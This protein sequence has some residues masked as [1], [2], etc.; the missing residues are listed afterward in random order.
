MAEAEDVITDAARHATIFARGLWQR[1]RAVSGKQ[2]PA[3]LRLADVAPRIDLLITAVFGRSFAI[4]AAQPPA[5]PT[6]LARLLQ[7]PRERAPYW[8]AAIGATDGRQI[9][10]PPTFDGALSESAAVAHWR[11]LALRQAMR[12]VRAG[13]AEHTTARD[14][15]E[16]RRMLGSATPLVRDLHLLFEAY[17]AD[18]A[19]LRLL[20]GRRD[21][22]H[23]L[24][25]GS[26]A[27]RPSL[28]AFPARLQRFE[29]LVRHVLGGALNQHLELTEYLA[30]GDLAASFRLH[31]SAAAYI[32]AQAVAEDWP[33]AA[34][35]AQVA[36]PWLWR[37]QWTGD[38]RVGVD[39]A[40]AHAASVGTTG[41]AVDEDQVA[42]RSARLVRRPDVRESIDGEEDNQSPGAWMVQTAAPHEKAEDPMGLQRPTDQDAETA[43]D[44][45]ADALSELP[46]ARLVST[47]GAPKEVLLSDDPPER[48]VAPRSTTATAAAPADAQQRL[49]YPEWDWRAQAYREPGATVWLLPAALG[50]M[51][52]V[53]DTLAARRGMLHEIRRRFELLRAQRVRLRRQLDGDAIDLAAYVE[54]RAQ[55]DAGLPLD[56]RLYESERRSRRDL[57]VLLLVD[58]SGSTDS[59]IAAGQ[60]IIDVEREALLLVCNALDGM[61]APYS[62]QA[63]SGEGPQRVVVRSVKAFSERFDDTVARRIAGLEPERYTRAGAALRHAT[64]LLSAQPAE[65]RLLLLLSDGKPND[66]DAYEGRY[67][68]EDLRQAVVEARLQGVAPFCLTVD[69]Q[70]ASYLPAVFGPYH[71]ALLQ[72]PERL[73]TV[74]LDWL[75]RLVAT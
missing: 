26:W 36:G 55:F 46:E 31:T 8:R 68:V 37:D 30:T 4:R 56:Q 17:A 6:V 60:R 9:W 34:Q 29:R 58:V 69:R 44:D 66:S 50:P 41:L 23:E 27:Q 61:R 24:R 15:A 16:H 40:S 18:Q 53:D 75:R 52:W 45:F 47:P 25:V 39:R 11:L 1:R 63:F 19:L 49:D 65:H 62:V 67:G 5:P 38:L 64:A 59:Q 54:A 12:A 70:A 57:A 42:P 43:A 3:P 72:R 73:P 21:A 32:L 74:L 28:E 14:A 10:L 71:Y 7:K 22:L 20:P 51:Q 13:G 35:A 2:Q 33:D 48:R